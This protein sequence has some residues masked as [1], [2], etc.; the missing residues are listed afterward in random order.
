MNNKIVSF[1][2]TAAASLA[3]MASAHAARHTIAMTASVGG[4]CTI[5]APTAAN[6][7][8]AN[9]TSLV[10]TASNG[11]A[12]AKLANLTLP[13]NCSSTNVSVQLTSASQGIT[14][15]GGGT[16]PSGQTNKIHYSAKFFIDSGLTLAT[17]NTSTASS[18]SP[19]IQPI[20]A[21]NL[22][23]EVNIPV[24]TTLLMPGDYSD[25]L[26]IDVLPNP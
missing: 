1:A 15:T 26:H 17:L 22:G 12:V 14:K 2:F 6:G 10:A 3:L 9:G 20:P 23:I 4:V 21:G 19:V 13:Y 11:F 25:S 8:S 5:G 16:V 24:G 18:T 7:F